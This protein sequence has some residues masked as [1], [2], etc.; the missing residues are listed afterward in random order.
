MILLRGTRGLLSILIGA[1]LLT[2]LT[3][4]WIAAQVIRRETERQTVA[5]LHSLAMAVRSQIAGLPADSTTSFELLAAGLGSATGARVTFINSNGRVLGDSEGEA[6]GLENH[7]DR[8][9]VQSALHG[10][11]GVARR[12]SPTIGV[13]LLYVAIPPA[14]PTAP[15]VRVSLP[16]GEGGSPFR[17]LLGKSLAT[18]IL[19]ALA[20][21]GALA[22]AMRRNRL[23][24]GE[25]IGGMK[26]W[27]EGRYNHRIVSPPGGDTELV[28]ESFN[29][30]AEKLAA[31]V[32]DIT[33]QRNELKAV[34]ASM[35]EG[36]IALDRDERI[37][38]I[39]RA[40]AKLF[41]I[42]ENAVA[43][44]TLQ[45]TF[46]NRDLQHFAALLLA[47]QANLLGELV[48]GDGRLYL[49]AHGS[50]INDSAQRPIG[51]LV[52]LNDVTE[53]RR[54]E[55]IRRDFVANVSHE[56]R[57]PITS[58]K[59]FVETLSEGA[60]ANR[61]SAERFLEIIS[62]Q[63]DRMNSIIEDLLALAR[64][65]RDEETGDIA[66]TPTSLS[67]L[68]LAAVEGCRVKAAAKNVS[69]EIE[70]VEDISALIN[71]P[72]LEQALFNLLDNAIAYSN[73]G[74]KVFVS[75]RH[76]GQ[77]VR[78]TVADEGPGIANEHLPRLFERFYR[79]DRH[80]SRK[81]GGT[82][83]GL[84][85]VK[86]IAQAH[87]GDVTVTSTPGKGSTFTISLPAWA[88]G[89]PPMPPSA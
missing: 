34:L 76:E 56:L 26:A 45:E 57:T 5:R 27:T 43:G 53:L 89:S 47:S 75:A 1:L 14:Y 60:L 69:I 84:A 30:A 33:R 12:R 39:N 82:G 61:E 38:Y 68:L 20:A 8:P 67:A 77:C 52:V 44:R 88:Q 50:A 64:L 55:R 85:I 41:G 72:L 71:P 11:F 79:V 21:A 48:I 13:E 10:E 40:T 22:A 66:L 15:L 32:A 7:S 58:I 24:V 37:T 73:A 35:V 23:F 9:E 62:R 2:T 17:E 4:V 49:Q 74:T 81:L 86:H 3:V 83:L 59:G 87:R 51:A 25:F 80:R 29:L 42:E 16:T 63:V 18:A 6:G 19:I 54:M 46:R 65:E 70:G 36:V 78:I 31:H 28:A